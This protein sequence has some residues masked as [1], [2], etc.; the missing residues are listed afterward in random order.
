MQSG[1]RRGEGQ[2]EGTRAYGGEGIRRFGIGSGVGL[3]EKLHARACLDA[4]DHEGVHISWLRPRMRRRRRR[5]SA[6]ALGCV[7]VCFVACARMHRA[8]RL[9]RPGARMATGEG[10]C[11]TASRRSEQASSTASED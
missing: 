5:G 10:E 7:Q 4:R 1:W 9:Q 3:D 6:C 2:V 11:E 8:M